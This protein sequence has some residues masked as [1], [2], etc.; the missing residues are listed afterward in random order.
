MYGTGVRV[1]KETQRYK[2]AKGFGGSEDE[3]TRCILKLRTFVGEQRTSIQG[4]FI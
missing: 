1:A 2:K 4:S 3:F